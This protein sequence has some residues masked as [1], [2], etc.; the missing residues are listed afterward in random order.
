MLNDSVLE[1][2]KSIRNPEKNLN[3]RKKKKLNLEQGKNIFSSHL[4]TDEELST[5]KRSKS[6]IKTLA[7]VKTKKKAADKKKIVLSGVVV[8]LSAQI[9]LSTQVMMMSLF[10]R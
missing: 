9:C 6:E 3:K 1:Y 4:Q 2:L 10:L 5:S 8:S 7:P